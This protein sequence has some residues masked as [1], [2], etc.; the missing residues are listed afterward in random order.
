MNTLPITM[1]TMIEYQCYAYGQ[2]I[3]LANEPIR[4]YYF[5]RYIQVR[6]KWNQL[7]EGD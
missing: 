7:L 1:P 5:N 2:A 4:N 6:F 3:I